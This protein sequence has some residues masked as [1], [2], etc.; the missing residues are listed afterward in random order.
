MPR[1]RVGVRDERV[2]RA[3]R[4]AVVDRGLRGGDAGGE[5]A[6]A[7][8]GVDRRARVQH[9]EVAPRARSPPKIARVVAALSAGEPP[10]AASA[11]AQV[12]QA[13]VLRG[14]G[15]AAHVRAVDLEDRRGGGDAQL[16]EG[17]LRA[18]DQCSLDTKQRKRS[19]HRL[20]IPRIGH[21]DELSA[22]AR[23]VRQRAEEVE[24]R[25]DGELLAHR[26]DEARRLVVVGREHE[27]E[28]DLVDAAPDRLGV[29]SMRTPSASSTSAEPERLVAV[30][31]PC[32]ATAQPAA[33]AMSAAVVETLKVDLP[34][35][36]PAVSTRSWR[37]VV[38]GVANA[39]I[40]RARPAS[41][42]TVSPFVRS[43]IS[44]PAICV[45]EA[46]P[47]MMTASTSA[48]SSL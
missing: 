9:G 22:R 7:A 15:V 24:D 4:R 13:H 16:V 33:A 11:S 36:V 34:P 38:T 8:G 44:R 35:P 42:A 27:A 46:S 43:A 2:E 21:A 3:R 10:A 1:T 41:S 19:G 17:V 28:A 12:L 25:A 30:R 45:S 48:A 23:R 32:L 39:R 5:V 20:H 37:L 29:R 18:H 47:A 31:L 40:V 26:D 6:G 14:H